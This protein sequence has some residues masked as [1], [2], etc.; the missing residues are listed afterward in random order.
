MSAVDLSLNFG[1]LLQTVKDTDRGRW[2]LT[3][4]EIRLRKSDT[5]NILAS[6][7]KLESVIVGMGTPGEASADA[8]LVARAKAAISA[9]R[10]EIAAIEGGT[11]ALSDEGR[12]F[13]KLADLAR[14]AFSTD[15]KDITPVNAGICRALQ[16]VDQLDQD[17]A[18]V[19]MP[20]AA[21]AFAR[22][23]DVFEAPAQVNIPADILEK[24]V[25]PAAKE[26]ARDIERGARL[27]IRKTG[28]DGEQQPAPAMA[29]DEPAGA[30][31]PVSAEVLSA[32]ITAT[33]QTL[34]PP[35]E[36]QSRVVIIRRK[37]EDLMDVPM[38]DASLAESAA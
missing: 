26:P 23:A 31:A 12:L 33:V 13:S 21:T 15:S 17:F 35:V 36:K 8:T 37:P 38:M 2:F 25:K 20:T 16:L 19:A 4:F 29:P 1:D 27:V 30:P 14:T 22:D 18:A 3:E 34:S 28:Q 5:G 9:A 7:A 24:P 11:P 10:R 32:T 6:I